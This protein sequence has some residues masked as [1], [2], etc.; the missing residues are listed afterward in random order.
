M[1]LITLLSSIC[2]AA[3]TAQT[4][5]SNGQEVERDIEEGTFAHFRFYL[6]ADLDVTVWVGD[7]LNEVVDV[8]LRKDFQPTLDQYDFRHVDH[9]GLELIAV[10]Q[11]TAGEW[12]LSLYAAD[13]PGIFNSKCDQTNLRVS[14]PDVCLLYDVLH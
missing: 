7:N 11:L 6:P 8:Y 14:W 10:F 5:L 1:R 9:D 4:T 3:V 13:C 2:I 12:R